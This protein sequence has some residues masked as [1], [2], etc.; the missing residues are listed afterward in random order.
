MR[1]GLD[2]RLLGPE[3]KGLGRYVEH[4]LISLAHLPDVQPVV[5][6]MS[7]RVD[8]ARRLAPHADIVPV[9][10]R[11]YTEREQVAFPLALRNH[12]VDGMHYPHFNVP[13]FGR[14][15]FVVT[16][17]DL[18]LL[19]HPSSRA[20]L[21]G[22]ARFYAKRIAWQR[23]LRSALKRARAIITPTEYVA[24]RILHYYP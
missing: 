9:D 23:V 17:H 22:P 13:L 11:W 5:F 6:T 12:P 16:I 19:E 20:S 18:L 4:A 1:L 24:Q 15:P 7:S 3:Q 14:A 21:L 10:V 2:A 8:Y